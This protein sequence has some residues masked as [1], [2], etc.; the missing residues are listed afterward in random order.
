MKDVKTGYGRHRRVNEKRRALES[1]CAEAMHLTEACTRKI[2][3]Q[4]FGGDSSTQQG[5]T[6]DPNKVLH[7]PLEEVKR[8][9]V[10]FLDVRTEHLFT[11]L[12]GTLNTGDTRSA[13]IA[14]RKVT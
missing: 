1:A 13:L 12:S 4:I 7:M 10:M 9:L 6:C 14:N 2:E 11:A 3:R 8:G 5:P